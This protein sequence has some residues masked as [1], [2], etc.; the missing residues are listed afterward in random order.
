MFHLPRFTAIFFNN[1]ALAAQ[2]P[3]CT[4]VSGAS[5]HPEQLLQAGPRAS[6]FGPSG[7]QERRGHVSGHHE[8]PSGCHANS[9]TWSVVLQFRRLEQFAIHRDI[10]NAYPG[11]SERRIGI[12]GTAVDN[13][14]WPFKGFGVPL[15]A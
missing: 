2:T 12:S 4:P 15:P 6:P 5:G 11:L 1:N 13:W 7:H 9:G 8:H 14:A 3:P 10:A